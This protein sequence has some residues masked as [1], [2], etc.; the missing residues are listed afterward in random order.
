[1][2]NLTATMSRPSRRTFRRL[3]SQP[4]RRRFVVQRFV[5]SCGGRLMAAIGFHVRYAAIFACMS[6]WFEIQFPISFALVRRQL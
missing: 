3:I 6:G 2:P 5:C 1:M 4:R